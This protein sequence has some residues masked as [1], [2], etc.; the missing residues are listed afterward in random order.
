MKCDIILYLIL[1][2]ILNY[3]RYKIYLK[4]KKM[5][6]VY[7]HTYYAYPQKGAFYH[8]KATLFY[9]IINSIFIYLFIYIIYLF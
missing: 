8:Y 4:I 3:A 1:S 5:S 9:H 6:N 7:P 2:I